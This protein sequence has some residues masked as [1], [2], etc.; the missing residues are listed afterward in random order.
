MLLPFA[1]IAFIFFGFWVL[2]VA[3]EFWFHPMGRPKIAIAL[4]KSGISLVSLL[5][6]LLAPASFA[7]FLHPLTFEVESKRGEDE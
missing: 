6:F 4:P 2:A 5:L 7:D 1:A 3:I